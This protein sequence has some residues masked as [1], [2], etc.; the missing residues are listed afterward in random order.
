[1]PAPAAPLPQRRAECVAELLRALAACATAARATPPPWPAP[2][3][4]LPAPPLADIFYALAPAG[5]A[6][7]VEA[8][9]ALYRALTAYQQLTCAE[10]EAKAAQH[11]ADFQAALAAGDR[12][13]IALLLTDLGGELQMLDHVR[14]V[15]PNIAPA[16]PTDVALFLWRE[17]L[18]PWSRAVALAHN[19]EP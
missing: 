15:T 18:L 9:R 2:E 8:H 19:C 13:Q 3:P 17:H 5:A 11:P 4:R 10:A 16:L 7:P 12:E 14:T 1:M 6:D